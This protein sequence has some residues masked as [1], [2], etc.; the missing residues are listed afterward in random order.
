MV[1][2]VQGEAQLVGDG[3]AGLLS[4]VAMEAVGALFRGAPRHSSVRALQAGEQDEAHEVDQLEPLLNPSMASCLVHAQARREACAW[5]GPA[6][7]TACN[8]CTA[9]R[10]VPLLG[11]QSLPSRTRVHSG[12]PYARVARAPEGPKRRTRQGE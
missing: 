12:R 11:R 8:R 3:G 9:R 4:V 10:G 2:R 6:R 5:R 1:Q 7:G